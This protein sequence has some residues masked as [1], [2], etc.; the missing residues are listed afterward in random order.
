[1]QRY[2]EMGFPE[3]DAQQAIELYGD[4]LHAG[5]HWLMLRQTMGHMPKRLKAT[6]GTDESTYLGSTVRY[7]GAQWRVD[8]FDVQHA[9]IMVCHCLTGQRRWI[10]MSDGRIEWVVIRHESPMGAGPKPAWHRTIGQIQFDLAAIEEKRNECTL[11]NVLHMYKRF[12]TRAISM[13]E[14]RKW[15]MLAALT[16]SFCHTPTRPKPRSYHSSDLHQF[17]IELMTYFHALCDVYSVSK[18]DFNESL[19]N[20]TTEATAC[21][22][23][24]TMQ[25]KMTD[26]IEVWKAPRNFLVHESKKWHSECVPMVIFRPTVLVGD[27]A[28]LCVC[29]VVIHDL[30]F[31]R[32]EHYD[33]SMNVVHMQCLFRHIFQ[34]TMVIKSVQ[35]VMD[36][37]FLKNTLRSSRKS[38]STS[39][40]PSQAFH[41][42]LFKY[43]TK[44][45]S[46][47]IGRET[48][49][50]STSS[51]GWARHDQEGFVFHTSCFGFMS[52]SS[53]N[54]TVR[55]GLLAQSVGMGKTVE[56]LALIA[57][58]HLT[59]PT[60]VVVPTTMLSIWMSEAAKYC[61]GLRAVL[62]HG[63]RRSQITMD[64]LRA[65]DI[66]VTTYRICVNET[67]RHVPTLGGIRWGRII[68]DESHELKSPMSATA[69]AMCR[70][71]APLRWCISA[72]P[73]PKGP[74]NMASLLAFMGVTPFVEMCTASTMDHSSTPLQVLARAH[75]NQQFTSLVRQFLC[76]ITFWQQK[77][78]VR[79]DLPPV[80][81]VEDIVP[82]ENADVYQA[83]CNS[84]L[85]RLA[86]DAM[87]TSHHRKA[88]AMHYMRWLR[89]ASTHY[90]LNATYVYGALQE[91]NRAHS[92]T[93]TVDAFIESLGSTEYDQSL[94]EVVDSWVQGNETCAI[95]RDVM[96]RPTLTPCQH[97]FCYE[98]IQSAYEHD[99]QRRCPLCRKPAE[100]GLLREL[101]M[102]GEAPS[103]TTEQHW[104]STDNL[105]YPVS[106]PMALHTKIVSGVSPMKFRRLVVLMSRSDEKCVVFTQYN[107]VLLL[108]RAHFDKHSIPYV[109]IEGRM[110]PSRRAKSIDRFQTS[111]DVRVFLMTTKTA[112]VG[113]TLT[114]ASHIYFLE[115][116]MDAH[117]R[118]QA[119]GRAWR[120]GQ[121]KPVTVTTLR[122]AD[123]FE[124]LK[125]A[126]F[127]SHINSTLAHD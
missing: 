59:D 61:P 92:T 97:M 62:F 21:L 98:C 95:C 30:T 79:L 26:R 16:R 36:D 119:V 103:S 32:P 64:Q 55:G 47:L 75:E 5:C 96:E 9:L 94:R 102:N 39:T 99:M 44:C 25:A 43:Q 52:R 3:A 110:T 65:A 105:G 125:T 10:H 18:E 49:A 87:E 24:D 45:L 35:G 113:I 104:S 83:L 42:T 15:K 40:V 28:T 76:D 60:L 111:D 34:P 124:G 117:V 73:Y 72:T 29:D 56:M 51:W 14:F 50:Q 22:F 127:E 80:T 71:Y 37:E 27:P 100:N 70:L 108:L 88:R 120:I 38:V 90:A 46:W 54:D 115:P 77:R 13:D 2:V 68:L 17:R 122:T 1:M 11:A 53:P 112:S 57:T 69:R 114:A 74:Q 101:K 84:I 106:M 82:L 19:Y 31:V 7:D 85:Q 63:P 41:G 8:D 121:T 93:K 89:L 107:S 109:S 116:C 67:Q 48:T 23:P 66:V 58:Q 33:A 91:N 118:K 6:H 86:M 12:N 20:N 123:T 78:H 126:D 4:D 81:H